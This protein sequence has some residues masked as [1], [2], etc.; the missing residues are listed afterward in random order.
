M[1]HSRTVS[2][3]QLTILMLTLIVVPI[4]SGVALYW[5]A[6]RVAE[7]SLPAEIK[8]ASV[9]IDE[10]GSHTQ[11]SP[12]DSATAADSAVSQREAT[13]GDIS[14]SRRLV[15]C[16][17]IKNVSDIDF[18]K[19][20]IGLNDQFFSTGNKK[21]PAGQE[22]AIPLESFIARNGSVRFPVG[23]RPIHKATV[24]AQLGV[25]ARGVSEYQFIG[26]EQTG[27]TEW[28]IPQPKNSV[29]GD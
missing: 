26:A 5:N 10:T 11:N 24:F 12:G 14:R 16:I 18:G 28:K 3:T 4:L 13:D 1:P 21:L 19:L 7:A 15:Q 8:I 6:P 17:V 27:S 2:S 25:G 29:S 23:N 20:S 9:W 22:V